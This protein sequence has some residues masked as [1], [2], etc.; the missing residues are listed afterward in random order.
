MIHQVPGHSPEAPDAI[1][2]IK[3]KYRKLYNYKLFVGKIDPPSVKII[4]T[5]CPFQLILFLPFA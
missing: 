1:R 5:S 2:A 4:Y 3:A